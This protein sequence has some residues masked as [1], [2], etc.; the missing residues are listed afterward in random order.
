M[1]DD[2]GRGPDRIPTISCRRCD[3]EWDL[4]YELEELGVGNQAIE[5]FALDH[6]RHTGHFPDDVSTWRARCRHCP[7]EVERLSESAIRR[8]A[9]VHARHASHVVAYRQ[10][11]M[12]ESTIVD[13]D[14]VR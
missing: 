8:W 2:S 4:E 6:Q 1:N 5:Q 10:A 13:P 14:D 9:E 12:D 3:R 11:S 7:E